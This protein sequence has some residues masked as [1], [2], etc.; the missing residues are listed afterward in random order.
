MSLARRACARCSGAVYSGTAVA[1]LRVIIEVPRG[2]FVKRTP[3]GAIDFVTPMPSPFNYG[4]VE[5]LP[6]SADGDPPDALVLGPRLVLGTA[7]MVTSWGAVDFIDAGDHD[8]KFICTLGTRPRAIDWWRVRTFFMVYAQFKAG[9][10]R[11]RGR[12]GVTRVR[13]L[14]V[15]EG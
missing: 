1:E 3:S 7:L 9:L 15:F 2:S 4:S 8:P 12:R 6:C 5:G 11:A 13:G 10:N 14:R